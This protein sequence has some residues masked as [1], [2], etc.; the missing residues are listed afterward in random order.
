MQLQGRTD[1]W[2]LLHTWEQK[3]QE[4]IAADYHFKQ[5]VTSSKFK[6]T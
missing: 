3:K 6:S 4:K 5:E 2:S 1:P